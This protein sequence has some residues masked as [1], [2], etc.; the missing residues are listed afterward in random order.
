MN[1]L[2]VDMDVELIGSSKSDVP[3]GRCPKFTLQHLLSECKK[4]GVV[5]NLSWWQHLSIVV[6]F[7]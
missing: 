6:F 2:T 4:T 3:S 5:I 1:V 7:T